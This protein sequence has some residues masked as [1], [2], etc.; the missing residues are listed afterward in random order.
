MVEDQTVM[1]KSLVIGMTTSYAASRQQIL[2][3]LKPSI[4]KMS[5]LS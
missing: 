1:E 2:K 4:G 5:P 3:A